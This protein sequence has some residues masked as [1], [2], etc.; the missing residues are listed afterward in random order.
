MRR[1]MQK[2]AL[3]KYVNAVICHGLHRERGSQ[4]FFAAGTFL[5][6]GHLANGFTDKPTSP[7]LILHGPQSPTI[8][9]CLVYSLRGRVYGAVV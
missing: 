1:K 2:F 4:Q 7:P 5:P 3:G 6:N 9:F 8:P